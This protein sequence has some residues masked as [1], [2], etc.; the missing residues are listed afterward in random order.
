MA[1]TAKHRSSIYQNIAPIIGEEEAGA[2]LDQFP[3]RDLDEPVTKD[4]VRADVNEVRSEMSAGFAE[5][6][7]EFAA[8]RSE[9]S[10]G[11]AEVRVEVNEVRSE[12]SAG[13]AEVRVETTQLRV[14]LLEKLSDQFRWFIGMWLTTIGLIVAVALRAL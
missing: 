13:F 12:M 4:F 2:L 8:V 9:M 1:L 14:E 3:S 10:A 7:V 5:V 6:H 11:F